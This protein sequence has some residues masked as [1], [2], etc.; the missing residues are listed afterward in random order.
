M[1]VTGEN[2]VILPDHLRS[3]AEQGN[4][5]FACSHIAVLADRVWERAYQATVTDTVALPGIDL[6][7]RLA[8]EG[9][10]LAGRPWWLETPYC[11]STALA[12]YVGADGHVYFGDAAAA[13]TV[14][15]TVLVGAAEPLSGSGSRNDP[16]VLD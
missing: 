9:R 14:R 15:P 5:D 7:A 12:R 3:E 11:P 1:L 6:A 10:G 16:F 8:R 2:P 13:R 4:L